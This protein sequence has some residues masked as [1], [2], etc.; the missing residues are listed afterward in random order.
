MDPSSALFDQYD[1]DYCARATAVAARIDELAGL[2][3]GE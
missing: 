2:S 1:A 3:G